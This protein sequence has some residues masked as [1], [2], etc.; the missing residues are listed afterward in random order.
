MNASH[1]AVQNGSF[2]PFSFSLMFENSIRVI[3]GKIEESQKILRD[4]AIAFKKH[5]S[6]LRGKG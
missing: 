5:V 1:E 3:R 6:P 4:A 2:N